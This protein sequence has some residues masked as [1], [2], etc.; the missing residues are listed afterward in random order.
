MLRMLSILALLACFST[1]AARGANDIT[2]FVRNQSRNQPSGGDEVILLQADQKLSEEARTKTDAQGAFT[3][4]VRHADKPYW[5][6]V[7]H[8]GVNYD[9]QASVGAVLSLDV[10]DAASQVKGITGSIEILR[11]G[12]NGR[13]LHVSDMYEIKNESN[14]PVTRSGDRTFEVY[15]PASAK[16]DSVLAAG[17]GN[18][19]EMISAAPVPGEPGHYHVSFPL[20]PGATK[21]A[22]NYDLPYD[23][24]AAFRTKRAYPVQQFAVM[25]PPT[26][27]FSSRSPAFQILA[28]GNTKYQ[29]QAANQLKAGEGP[30]FEISGAGALPPLG[31]QAKSKAAAQPLAVPVPAV[32][33][34]AREASRASAPTDSRRELTQ[35]PSQLL[36][37]GILAA[38]LLTTCAVLVW[39]AS[40]SRSISGSMPAPPHA[41]KTR[42]SA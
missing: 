24:H 19:G 36:F 18:I 27:K 42:P 34:P 21:F 20:R 31:E 15:L 8:Q 13:L 6:R 29:V 25:I 3:F 26:M 4:H 33:A 11:T 41:D 23:G 28:T 38:V 30:G 7:L 14:P 2:G 40:K 32:P 1:P 35:P 9:Q 5:V 37:L 10:F 12:T 17:P 22:F 39:R 16:M